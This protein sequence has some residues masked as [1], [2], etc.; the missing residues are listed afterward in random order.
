[1]KENYAVFPTYSCAIGLCHQSVAEF[2]DPDW[3][4][5]VS[6]GIGLSYQSARLNGLAGRYDPMPES[7]LSPIPGSTV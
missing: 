1:M 5:K 4:Y 2:I 7:T 3:G 6:S